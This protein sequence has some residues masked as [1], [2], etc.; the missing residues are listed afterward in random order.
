VGDGHDKDMGFIQDSEVEEIRE[1]ARLY[2]PVD[3]ADLRPLC[4]IIHDSRNRS[5]N[6][7]FKALSQL[8][9]DL[10]VSISGEVEFFLG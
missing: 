9:S 1:A 5:I 10:F 8:G 7:L 6:F 3:S 4:W 2:P